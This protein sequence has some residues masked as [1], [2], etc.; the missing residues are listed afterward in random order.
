MGISEKIK[1]KTSPVSLYHRQT[2]K[3]VKNRCLIVMIT[4][5][6]LKFYGI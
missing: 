5:Y 3:I 2:S 6:M 4:R 1:V